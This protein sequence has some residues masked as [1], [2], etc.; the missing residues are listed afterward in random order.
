MTAAAQLTARLDD[1]TFGARLPI[2]PVAVA[3][4]FCERTLQCA[5]WLLDDL[6]WN[7][8]V[9]QEATVRELTASLQADHRLIDSGVRDDDVINARATATLRRISAIFNRAVQ[10]ELVY[11]PYDPDALVCPDFH[12]E[13]SR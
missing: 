2:R 10:A 11:S 9:D 8:G 1:N 7:V 6:T 13:M 4:T 3:N 5:C 12:D